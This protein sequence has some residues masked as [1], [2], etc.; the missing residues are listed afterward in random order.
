MRRF[1]EAVTF[2]GPSSSLVEFPAQSFQYFV[3]PEQLNTN[4]CS[5]ARE[6]LLARMDVAAL[7][8]RYRA[9][10]ELQPSAMSSQA[11]QSKATHTHTH[12]DFQGHY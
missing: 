11:A 9:K 1:F 3:A 12:V 6:V 7:V 5:Y 10:R 4:G 8:S 2:S